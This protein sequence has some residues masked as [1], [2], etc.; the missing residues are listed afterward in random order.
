MVNVGVQL[1]SKWLL[2]LFIVKCL[3]NSRDTF[4]YWEFS[5]YHIIYSLICHQT[6]DLHVIFYI[7]VRIGTLLHNSLPASCDSE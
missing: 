1:I 2:Y 6:K 3:L 4:I 5:S 7:N